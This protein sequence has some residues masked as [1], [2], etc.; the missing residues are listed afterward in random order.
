MPSGGGYIINAVQQRP[1]DELSQMMQICLDSFGAAHDHLIGT[2]LLAPDA[3][4]LARHF[5]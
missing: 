4:E 2:K 3:A 1:A 5:S